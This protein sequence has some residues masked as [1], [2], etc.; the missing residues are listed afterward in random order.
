M[1]GVARRR[2]GD[3]RLER[4]VGVRPAAGEVAGQLADDVAVAG[5]QAERRVAV[6]GQPVGRRDRRPAP[7]S[8][9]SPAAPA[10]ST[11][12]GQLLGLLDVG[13]VERVDAEDR[14]GDRGGD[15]PADELAAEV[16][17]VV[18]ARSG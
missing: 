8:R 13:L 16:D 18:D 5:G 3:E 15:L 2:R 10:A 9:P 14:A 11:S 6:E 12:P 4:E 7:A 1:R 17:R